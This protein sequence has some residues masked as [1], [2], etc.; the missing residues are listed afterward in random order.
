MSRFLLAVAVG[1]LPFL[2]HAAGSK[3]PLLGQPLI[4]GDTTAEEVQNVFDSMDWARQHHEVAA[5]ATV[6][7]IAETPLICQVQIKTEDTF[8]CKAKATLRLFMR[9]LLI[10]GQVSLQLCEPAPSA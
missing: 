10:D 3:C 4:C 5:G 6:S 8:T 9:R 1:S 7:P 2:A